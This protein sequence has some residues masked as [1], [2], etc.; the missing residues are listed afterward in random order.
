MIKGCRHVRLAPS[1]EDIEG[2]FDYDVLIGDSGANAMLGQPGKDSFYGRGGNDVI[3]AR[4]GVRDEASSAA[5]KATPGP[6]PHRLL[7]PP[8]LDCADH[9]NGTPVAGLN[10]GG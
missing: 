1:D 7:R 2:S 8:P 10:N 9:T 5:P 4:D 3:D 6:R